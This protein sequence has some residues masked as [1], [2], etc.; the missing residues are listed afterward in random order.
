ME[1]FFLEYGGSRLQEN[2]LEI[3]KQSSR[4]C[5]NVRHQPEAMNNN[6]EGHQ[7]DEKK[8]KN[9]IF[10]ELRNSKRTNVW[11]YSKVMMNLQTHKEKTESS[12]LRG[13]PRKTSDKER[14]SVRFELN[15]SSNEKEGLQLFKWKKSNSYM[16]AWTT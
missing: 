8:S 12:C 13:S 15:V 2:S 9:N 1:L 5:S 6:K 14:R 16:S 3:L 11:K 7:K 10:S 4:Y